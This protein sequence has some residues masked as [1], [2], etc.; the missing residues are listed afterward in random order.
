MRLP[1]FCDHHVHLG[2]VDGRQG[3]LA[4]S[5]I[6]RVVDLGWSDGVVALAQRSPVHAAYAGRFVAAP[7]GYPS[8]SRWAPPRC[9]SE[10]AEPR[11]AADAVAH[12]VALRASVVK[13]TLNRD[14]GPVPDVP[15]LR[16]VV[17]AATEA[18]LP[19]VAHAQGAGMVELALAGRVPAL[20]HTPWTHR[21]DDDVVAEAVGAGQA[22]VSTLDI[23]GYGTPTDDQVR[24]VDNLARFHAA[25][26]RVLYGTDLGNGP[27]PEALNPRELGLLADAGLS[28]D[29]LLASLTDPWPFLTHPTDAE[30]EVPDGPEPLLERLGR[31]RV[32]QEGA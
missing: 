24:A 22:W 20:A 19:V 6:G 32:A 1:A 12:Q 14:A 21:L 25:G 31:A 30:T 28:D 27:L 29:A 8:A 7:G 18:D 16:A 9:L 15:T 17:D 5:G 13:V 10:V 2:L 4:P 23:H 26:G 11:D 3:G